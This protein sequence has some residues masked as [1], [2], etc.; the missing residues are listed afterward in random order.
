[1]ARAVELELSRLVGDESGTLEIDAGHE[2][3]ERGVTRGVSG[4]GVVG[5]YVQ[6]LVD[7]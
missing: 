2:P 5:W 6:G 7:L 4:N 1:M 3:F